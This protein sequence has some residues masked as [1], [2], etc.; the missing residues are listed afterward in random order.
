MRAQPPGRRLPLTGRPLPRRRR[1]PPPTASA[2]CRS[3]RAR[4][5][6]ACPCSPLYCSTTRWVRRWSTERW[7][8][9][10]L[11]PRLLPACPPRPAQVLGSSCTLLSAPGRQVVCVPGAAGRR[12]PASRKGGPSLTR[13]T[14]RRAAEPPDAQLGVHQRAAPDLPG[15]LPAA[16]QDHLPRGGR[17][18]GPGRQQ[19]GT[20]EQG[21]ATPAARAC[22]LRA[23]G[24]SGWH[25]SQPAPTRW[26]PL[27]APSPA[28]PL[29][30]AAGVR[31]Q[32]A[33]ARR[34]GAVRSQRARV[35]GAPQSAG[36]QRVPAAPSA[37]A[38]P[39]GERAK[40]RAEA[41][42]GLGLG[43]GLG[44]GR[45]CAGEASCVGV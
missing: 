9:G 11:G 2:C 16:Q 7:A 43:L 15:L 13:A 12:A 5:W 26:R 6:R 10:G 21:G 39:A 30:A 18:A 27:T 29:P 41:G 42:A 36:Q 33:G 23:H 14:P 28:A 37:S 34:A 24:C 20:A 25:V 40:A 22:V 8:G 17:G 4:S 38:L 35:H 44:H 19:A 3:R 32:R 45:Q 31:A 1:G